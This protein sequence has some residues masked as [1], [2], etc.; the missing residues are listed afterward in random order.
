MAHL[1][2]TNA[3]CKEKN[4]M[5]LRH[6]TTTAPIGG[7][8]WNEDHKLYSY[9]GGNNISGNVT[10]DFANGSY[11][12]FE[13]SGNTTFILPETASGE[14][15]H[16]TLALGNSS[17]GGHA[18]T[19]QPPSGGSIMWVGGVAPEFS[20]QPDAWNVVV[21]VCD[22]FEYIGDGGKLG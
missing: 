4:E 8:Q 17:T 18:I 22:F 21:L 19:F 2:K 15:E 3:P 10:L 11:Q 1:H 6:K 9:F 5:K 16:L 12:S 13:L 20:L 14:V 7:A